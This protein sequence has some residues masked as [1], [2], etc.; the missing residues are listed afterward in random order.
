MSIKFGGAALFSFVLFSA[1]LRAEL[2]AELTRLDE[3]APKAYITRVGSLPHSVIAAL[4]TVRGLSE[5]HMADVGGDWNLTDSVTDSSLPFRRLIWAVGFKGYVVV[6]Y[7]V[8]GYGHSYHVI[9][10]SP[11]GPD[12]A[13]SV[14]W[15]AG[16]FERANDYS[17]FVAA[18]RRGKMN[19]DARIIH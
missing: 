10:L 17:E 19:S 12:G 14:V 16:S 4:R 15:A 3:G 2:P 13:R 1:P 7:E 9:V 5:F 18:Y 11:E 6:H 8:G